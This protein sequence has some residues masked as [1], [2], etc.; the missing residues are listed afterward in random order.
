MCKV[1][2]E[3]K[4]TK[5]LLPLVSPH[6]VGDTPLQILPHL[7]LAELEIGDYEE[8]QGHGKSVA[9]LCL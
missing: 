6:V 7:G 8:R 1:K 9:G 4:S 3:K 5:P 2:G